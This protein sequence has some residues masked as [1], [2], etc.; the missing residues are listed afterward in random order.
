MEV[1]DV[2]DSGGGGRIGERVRE[3]LL[4]HRRSAQAAQ[5]LGLTAAEDWLANRRI[6]LEALPR[7]LR[8]NLLSAFVRR[9][10]GPAA[11]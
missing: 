7:S 5:T 4:F 6:E 10:A 2:S 1:A 3:A 8:A 9:I 11:G